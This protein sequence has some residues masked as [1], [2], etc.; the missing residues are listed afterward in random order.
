MKTYRNSHGP[1]DSVLEAQGQ[2]CASVAQPQLRISD[3][4]LVEGIKYAL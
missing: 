2:G 1:D 4:N 3:Q